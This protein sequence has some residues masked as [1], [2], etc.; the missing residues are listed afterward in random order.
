MRVGQ[1]K[2]LVSQ[3]QLQISVA[4]K[5]KKKGVSYFQMASPIMNVRLEMVK[6]KLRS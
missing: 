3:L 1:E 5:K 2:C 4:E 6:C